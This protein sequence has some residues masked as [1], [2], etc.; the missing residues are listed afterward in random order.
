MTQQTLVN[1]TQSPWFVPPLG[2]FTFPEKSSP[3]RC[4]DAVLQKIPRLGERHSPVEAQNFIKYLKRFEDAGFIF[5]AIDHKN[6]QRDKYALN[7]LQKLLA[8]LPLTARRQDLITTIEHHLPPDISAK[9]RQALEEKNGREFSRDRTS[10]SFGAN[11]PN[12]QL[13][14]PRRGTRRPLIT[15]R[16]LAR[17]NARSSVATYLLTKCGSTS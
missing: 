6:S 14:F 12:S 13:T 1:W 7:A 10:M 2:Y 15:N 11:T 4:E 16:S 8:N 17:G 9:D 3:K 5:V